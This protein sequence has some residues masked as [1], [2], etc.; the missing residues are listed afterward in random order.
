VHTQLLRNRQRLE[1]LQLLATELVQHIAPQAVI[2]TGDLVDAKSA[3]GLFQQQYA[4][5]WEAY[6]NVTA[7]LKEQAGLCC[8]VLF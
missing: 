8:Q 4:W 5:E 6:A 7:T 1:D 2:I 3:D